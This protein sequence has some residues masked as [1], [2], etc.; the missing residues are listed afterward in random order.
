MT[1][2][3]CHSFPSSLLCRHGPFA[4]AFW[5]CHSVLS[6]LG[7]M[8]LLDLH[9][10]SLSSLFALHGQLKSFTVEYQIEISLGI[11]ATT[12]KIDARTE[13]SN[14]ELTI[15]QSRQTFVVIDISWT[16]SGNL[17]FAKYSQNTKNPCYLK[18]YIWKIL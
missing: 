13:L 15:S 2:C 5:A 3:H 6:I 16:N 4:I 12:G 17:K 9:W 11:T 14:P 10:Q 8:L 18:Y 1:H 7:S